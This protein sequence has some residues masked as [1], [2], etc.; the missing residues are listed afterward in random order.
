MNLSLLLLLVVIPSVFGTI[1]LI[2]SL[3]DTL[4][5]LPKVIF[6]ILCLPASIWIK[7]A[8]DSEPEVIT[9]TTIPVYKTYSL[10]KYFTSYQ[11]ENGKEI[12]TYV[13]EKYV[14]NEKTTIIQYKKSYYGIDM[15]EFNST[16]PKM[17]KPD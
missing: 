9:S 16:N 2:I 13:D 1:Y 10:G 14:N 17:K 15:S 12:L 5:N 6:I 11:D 8:T 7:I 4:P 3:F